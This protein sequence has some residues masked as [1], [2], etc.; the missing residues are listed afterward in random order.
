MANKIIKTYRKIRCREDLKKCINKVVIRIRT[1][2]KWG[3]K[4]Q[5]E[6]KELLFDGFTYLKK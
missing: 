4:L 3:E 6:R 2:K 1:L 5:R